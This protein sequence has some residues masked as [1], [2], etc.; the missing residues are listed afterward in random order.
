MGVESP[1]YRC[2]KNVLPKNILP[3]QRNREKKSRQT[4]SCSGCRHHGIGNTT[5]VYGGGMYVSGGMHF[6][7]KGEICNAFNPVHVF[8]ATLSQQKG[9]L[10]PVK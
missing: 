6:S 7:G 1:C 9:F 10:G 5:N 2:K 8:C 4:H 3:P